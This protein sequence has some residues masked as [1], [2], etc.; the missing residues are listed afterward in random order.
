MQ[1]RILDGIKDSGAAVLLHD[2]LAAVWLTN[3]EHLLSAALPPAASPDAAY[4]QAISVR[5]WHT[6]W[7]AAHGTA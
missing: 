5:P 6:S 7:V 1:I 4:Q 2:C 3:V